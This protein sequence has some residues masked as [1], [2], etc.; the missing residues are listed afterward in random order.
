MDLRPVC[1][2]PS[3]ALG[4]GVHPVTLNQHPSMFCL[5]TMDDIMILTYEFIK[6]LSVHFCF[7]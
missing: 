6:W 4:Y 1:L 5:G 3:D 7:A 2:K